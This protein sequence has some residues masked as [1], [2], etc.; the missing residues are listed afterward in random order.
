M[1]AVIGG[2][3]AIVSSAAPIQTPLSNVAIPISTAGIYVNAVTGVST[4]APSGSPGWDLNFW[5]TSSF[6]AWANNTA[7]PND[8]VMATPGGSTTLVGALS[9]G[10]FVD[11]SQNFIRTTAAP[12]AS[13]TGA[14]QVNANNY[15]GFRFLNEADGQLHY[16]WAMIALS[17]ALNTAPRSIVE[18]WYES[19]ANTGI[20]V[21]DTGATGV[22]EPSSAALLAL[23]AAGLAA[24]RRRKRK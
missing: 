21:G 6:R 14:F 11:S 23:G 12:V 15:I 18:M 9:A 24:L 8:G 10:T 3:T 20:Q 4:T 1:P 2:A 22:P 5:S 7:S 17:G 13:G 16:G 19:V